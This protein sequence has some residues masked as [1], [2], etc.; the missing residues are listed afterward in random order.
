[1][2]PASPVINIFSFIRYWVA[3]STGTGNRVLA[4]GAADGFKAN[5]AAQ[6]M[7]SSRAGPGAIGRWW[8]F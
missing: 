3:V 6:G 2:K 5:V 4:S 8:Y 1:M 7:C